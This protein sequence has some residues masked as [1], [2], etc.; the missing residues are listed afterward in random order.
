MGG[1]VQGGSSGGVLCL[2][3]QAGAAG[4]RAKSETEPLGLGLGNAIGNGRGAIGGGGR[5]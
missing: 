4:L 3:T 1:C 2:L 5:L